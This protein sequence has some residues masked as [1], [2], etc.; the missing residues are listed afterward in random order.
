MMQ[1]PDLRALVELARARELVSII[2]NT[3]TSPACFR[4][5]TIGFDLSVHSATKYLNGHSDLVAGAVAGRADLVAEIAEI[6]S[7]LGGSLDPHACFLLERGI[8]TMPLRVERPGSFFFH[9]HLGRSHAGCAI[10]ARS[11]SCWCC[12]PAAV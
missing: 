7:H 5:C 4:P 8:K 1:V 9:N 11:L 6:S 3:M 2:D 12:W 10:Y